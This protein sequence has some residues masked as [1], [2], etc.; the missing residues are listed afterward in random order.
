MQ[1]Q[2]KRLLLAVA[3]ALGGFLVWSMF[4]KRDEP[5]KPAQT[6]S[7]TTTGS[8]AA[9]SPGQAAAIPQI[10]PAEGSPGAQAAPGDAAT[11][12]LPFDRFVATFSSACGGLT[13]WKLT[14]E[15]YRRDTTRGELLPLR[16]QMTAEGKAVPAP[17]LANLPACGAFDTNFVTA[18]SKYVVP[19]GAVLRQIGK[20]TSELQSQ[21]PLVCRLLLEK[22]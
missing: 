11:I 5:A 15:R 21:F 19:R 9:P 12:V 7:Q 13:S 18:T 6:A 10:G 14:D 3:L 20:H 4:A 1:D 8:A 2:G 22:K 16:S 17:Q